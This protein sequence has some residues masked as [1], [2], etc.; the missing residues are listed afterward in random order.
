MSSGH[1]YGYVREKYAV[2]LDILGNENTSAKDRLYSAYISAWSRLQVTDFPEHLQGEFDAIS[3]ALT[4][5]PVDSPGEGT[6]D[7]SL[8]HMSDEE[9]ENLVRRMRQLYYDFLEHYKDRS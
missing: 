1:S 5:V 7:S 8:H 2:V 9:A 4:W 6:L 3:E